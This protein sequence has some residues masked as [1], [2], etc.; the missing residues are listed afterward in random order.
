M[1]KVDRWIGPVSGVLSIVGFVGGSSISGEVDAEPTDSARTVVAEFREISDDILLGRLVSL[2][3]IGF[4]LIFV[5]HLRTKFRDGGAGW[6]ADGFLA[7]GIAIAGAMVI[8][9]GVELAGAEAADR[10]HAEVAQ[11]AVDFLWNGT[12]LFSPGLLA[13][14]TTG[15]VASFSYRILPLWLGGLA[16]VVALGALAPWIGILVFGIWVLAASVVETVQAFR[17]TTAA[18]AS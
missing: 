8:F 1:D 14:G 13:V 5:G 11:G 10:G 17:Q 12:L 9:V 15:A 6:A 7:G 16:V 2:L 4:L 18:N 3:G